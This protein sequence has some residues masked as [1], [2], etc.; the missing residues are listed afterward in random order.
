MFRPLRHPFP[1]Q[2]VAATTFASRDATV[3]SRLNVCDAEAVPGIV[4]TSLNRG[5]DAA[6]FAS[7]LLDDP[8]HPGLSK[9]SNF[10]LAALAPKSD[11]WLD[12]DSS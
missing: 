7:E 3:L 8:V 11:T 6:P 10:E 9:C 12:R 1:V 5:D 4:C 2:N